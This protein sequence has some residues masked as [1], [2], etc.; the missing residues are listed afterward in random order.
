MLKILYQK[1]TANITLENFQCVPFRM[2]TK[3]GCP[4]T[5]IAYYIPGGLA[6]A[7]RIEK[8]LKTGDDLEQRDEN[9]TTCI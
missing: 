6:N 4:V 9:I 2:G 7:V 3:P 1:S 5:T 8:R